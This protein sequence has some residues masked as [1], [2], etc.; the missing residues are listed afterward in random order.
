LDESVMNKTGD[1]WLKVSSLCGILAPVIAFTCILYAIESYSQFSWFNNALSDLGVVEGA[2]AVSF[3]LGLTVGGVLAFVF[4]LGL[5]RFL[6]SKVLGVV[7][8]FFFILDALALTSIGIFPESARPMHY[9]ASVAFFGLFPISMLLICAELFTSSRVKM[10]L[11]TLGVAI[12]AAIVWIVQFTAR[13]FE[14]VAIPEALS[15][16]AASAWAVFL[17]FE[18]FKAT[19]HTEAK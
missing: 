3:N 5:F 10:G 19:S 7:G 15:A 1:V 13:P 18:M 14:G 16:L 17:G 6:H 11:F 9:Y 4:G 2:T 8:T 12:F